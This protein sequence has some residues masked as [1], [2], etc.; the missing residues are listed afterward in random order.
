MELKIDEHY[1]R[2]LEVTKGHDE[3]HI[4]IECII[5]EPKLVKEP[6]TLLGVEELGVMRVTMDGSNVQGSGDKDVH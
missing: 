5:S 6:K 4:Y 2:M 3:F 1:L